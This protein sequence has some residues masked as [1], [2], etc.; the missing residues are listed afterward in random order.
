MRRHLVLNRLI[1]FLDLPLEAQDVLLQGLDDSLQLHLLSLQGLDVIGSL[2]NLLLQA[3]EL[4]TRAAT[5]KSLNPLRL[6]QLS[7]NV[8]SPLSE[9]GR[10]RNF[11]GHVDDVCSVL[12]EKTQAHPSGGD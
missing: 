5:T 7:V 2:L 6:P 9:S 8:K 3:A 1:P 10:A 11:P 12:S 4:K